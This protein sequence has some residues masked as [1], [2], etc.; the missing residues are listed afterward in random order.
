MLYQDVNNILINN[1]YFVIFV[2]KHTIIH[3]VGT[4]YILYYM[5]TINEDGNLFGDSAITRDMTMKNKT[6]GYY[7]KINVSPEIYYTQFF[8]KTIE[9]INFT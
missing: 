9:P 3:D 1:V 4:L 8:I 7:Y 5:Q 2:F 6:I